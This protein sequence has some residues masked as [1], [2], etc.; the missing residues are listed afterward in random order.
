MYFNILDFSINWRSYWIVTFV[1]GFPQNLYRLFDRHRGVRILS[2]TFGILDI[3]MLNPKITSNLTVARIFSSCFGNYGIQKSYSS[4]S[5]KTLFYLLK[6]LPKNHQK[7][8]IFSKM[9]VKFLPHIY[10]LNYNFHRN[11]NIGFHKKLPLNEASAY[12]G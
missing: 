6:F 9:P 11:S 3:L 5:Q 10:Q 1:K 4:K 8:H 12:C 7:W 2:R